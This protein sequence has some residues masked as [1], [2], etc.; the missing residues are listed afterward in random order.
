MSPIRPLSHLS[1]SSFVVWPRPLFLIRPWSPTRSDQEAYV[2]AG[3]AFGSSGC[4]SGRDR[5][6]RRCRVCSADGAR[7]QARRPA[8]AAGQV[9]E[10]DHGRMPLTKETLGDQQAGLARPHRNAAGREVPER[11]ETWQPRPAESGRWLKVAEDRGGVAGN[12]NQLPV[13]DRADRRQGD[14][15]A[16]GALGSAPCLP[17]HYRRATW[18]AV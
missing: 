9:N 10:T 4:R 11:R 15:D 16:L 14:L 5:G 3:L 13:G 17:R 7:N 1:S 18:C 6:T 2:N 8:A 12:R